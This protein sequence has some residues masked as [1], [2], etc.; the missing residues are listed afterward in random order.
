MANDYQERELTPSIKVNKIDRDTFNQKLGEGVLSKDELYFIVPKNQLDKVLDIPTGE[1]KGGGIQDPSDKTEG[2][3][4]MFDGTDW[5]ASDIEIPPQ[6]DAYTKS[7]TD[8]LL[9]EKADIEM[10][11]PKMQFGGLKFTATSD[12]TIEMGKYGNPIELNLEYSSDDGETWSEFVVGTEYQ[13]QNGGTFCLRATE[14]GNPQGTGQ[15]PSG[16]KNYHK[17]IITGSVSA[18]GNI[19]SLYDTYGRTRNMTDCG[20]YYLFGTNECGGLVSIEGLDLAAEVLANQC[21][22]G[23]FCNCSNLTKCFGVLKARRLENGCYS[24][25][26]SGCGSLLNAPDIDATDNGCDLS[27]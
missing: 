2:Q 1:I 25:M 7:E 18:S 12:S 21:Y 23:M 27:D 8:E 13:I 4:L 9:D 10:L 26:F 22:E 15:N 20:F 17:F 11:P 5:V 16:Q 6:I 14:Q 3:Y 24:T 19:M